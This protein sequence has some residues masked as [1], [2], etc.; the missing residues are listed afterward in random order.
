MKFKINA[1]KLKSNLKLI[2]K[3]TKSFDFNNIAD[4]ILF[5]LEGKTLTLRARNDL[6]SAR[7]QIDM[8]KEFMKTKFLID[9][10]KLYKIVKFS[11]QDE[12]HFELQSEDT[13]EGKGHLV[14]KGNSV[15]KFPLKPL[16]QYPDFPD[17]ET[18]YIPVDDDFIKDLNNVKDFVHK[19]AT[20]YLSGVNINSKTLISTDKIVVMLMKHHYD[21]ENDVTISP[22]IPSLLRKIDNP[23]VS[24]KKNFCVR[25]TIKDCKIE[26]VHSVINDDFPV[27]LVLEEARKWGSEDDKKK[28]VIDKEDFKQ[29]NR[30][31][32]SITGRGDEE[33]KMDINPNKITFKYREKGF[34]FQQ[35]IPAEVNHSML[36]KTRCKRISEMLTLAIQYDAEDITFFVRKS[37]DKKYLVMKDNFMYVAELMKL[38]IKEDN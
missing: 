8:D 11:S 16:L 15:V 12:L 6:S 30:K 28:V 31:V 25:G 14:F 1:T 24:V 21:F 4:S 22:D 19:K 13:Q 23:E 5:K 2:N 10:N 33:I 7:I 37:P 3:I 18:N 34:S 26:T 35:T 29:I 38:E 9:A 36:I 27:D 32:K 17:I 20:N